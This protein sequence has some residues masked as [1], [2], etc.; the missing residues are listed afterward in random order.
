MKENA[1][2]RNLI[3]EIIPLLLP[4]LTGSSRTQ[5]HILLSFSLFPWVISFSPTVWTLPGSAP[6]KNNLK[7]PIFLQNI[8]L[9][10]IQGAQNNWNKFKVSFFPPRYAFHLFIFISFK[11]LLVPKQEILELFKYFISLML[12]HVNC[13]WELSVLSQCI[14]T[15]HLL[16]SSL[17][18]MG[19]KQASLFPELL[20]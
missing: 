14:S 7:L 9:G 10:I 8:F 2:P 3:T 18:T 15:T 20:Q 1:W 5:A 19:L 6:S 12:S 13:Q 17:T 11:I 4:P 16:F